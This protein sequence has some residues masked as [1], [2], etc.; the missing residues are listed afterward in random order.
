[1]SKER[2]RR[3]EERERLAAASAA[4]RLAAAERRARHEARKRTLTRW[5]PERHSRQTGALAER[6]RRQVLATALIL[7][8]L[9]L[10]VFAAAQ[11]WPLTALTLV[12]SV[13]GAPVLYTM[14]FRRS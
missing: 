7:T 1:V 13:L 5:L 8:V 2:A 6:K 12:A 3:R 9:N 4:E 10:L 11:D 14:L